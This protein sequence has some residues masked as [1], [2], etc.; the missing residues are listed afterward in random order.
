MNKHFLFLS[1][2][3]SFSTFVSCSPDP[4]EAE[5]QATNTQNQLKTI[6]IEVISELPI[7]NTSAPNTTVVLN[8]MSLF[9]AFGQQTISMNTPNHIGLNSITQTFSG[10]SSL[11]INYTVQRAF[12]LIDN[13]LG[14][15]LCQCGDVT[16]KFYA[17]NVLFHTTTKELGGPGSSCSCPDGSTI[18][19]TVIV[20]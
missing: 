15:A 16:V 20:P 6:R 12:Y 8:S 17:D 14:T 18:Q 3:I 9:S 4:E 11:N 1:L 13:T 2:V 10:A 5:Q 7:S 19:E